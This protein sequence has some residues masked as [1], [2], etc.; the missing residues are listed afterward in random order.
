MSISCKDQPLTLNPQGLGLTGGLY[1]RLT[2]PILYG[3]WL[4]EGESGRSGHSPRGLRVR[5]WA[6]HDIDMTNIA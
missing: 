6:L 2:G 4:I 5:G 1:T 3:V